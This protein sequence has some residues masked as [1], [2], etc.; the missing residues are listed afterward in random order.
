MMDEGTLK[1]KGSVQKQVNAWRIRM[2][3]GLRLIV[4]IVAVMTMVWWLNVPFLD[5][6]TNDEPVIVTSDP[7]LED[8][9]VQ[10]LG[11][12]PRVVGLLD[13]GQVLDN[14][15]P[16]SDEKISALKV[17]DLVV[18]HGQ[19]IDHYRSEANAYLNPEANVITIG[20]IMAKYEK[21]WPKYYWMS[22][23]SWGKM[24]HYLHR[25]L[26]V[27]LPKY[28]YELAVRKSAYMNDVY[29]LHQT[30]KATLNVP[31]LRTK[32]VVT[33][34]PSLQL[35]ASTYGILVRTVAPNELIN[36]PAMNALI[37]SLKNEKLNLIIPNDSVTRDGLDAI[38]SESLKQGWPI[39][40]GKPVMSLNLSDETHGANTYIAMMELNA[41]GIVQ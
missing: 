24:L 36:G 18:W 38:V 2:K 33:N 37:A 10:L 31:E 8:A 7:I 1:A 41:K 19:G 21:K 4:A 14:L 16:L 40:V 9:I 15:P 30:I 26:A 20:E 17:A 34:H 35:L 12:E 22:P 6:Q 13:R 29:A 39:T 25:Q 27:F 23:I 32:T 28:Q 3:N 11:P 5:S